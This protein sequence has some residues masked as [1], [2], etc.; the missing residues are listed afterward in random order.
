MKKINA[1]KLFN[2]L[3]LRALYEEL[4]KAYNKAPENKVKESAAFNAGGSPK[5]GGASPSYGWSSGF[6]PVIHHKY[7]PPVTASETV[8]DELVF[9]ADS[10]S[11]TTYN[12]KNHIRALAY[13]LG[14]NLNTSAIM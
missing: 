14:L 10:A 4:T 6:K 12:T 9:K 5:T 13:C 8:P 7:M 2:P 11:Y 1:K 3:T